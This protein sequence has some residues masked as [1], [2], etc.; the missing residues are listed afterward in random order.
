MQTETKE[1]ILLTKDMTAIQIALL[2]KKEK[3]HI[4]YAVHKDGES[5]GG[6]DEQLGHWCIIYRKCRIGPW[7]DDSE[8]EWVTAKYEM[9]VDGKPTHNESDW[10]EV[11]L[12]P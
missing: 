3:P 10:T 1:P 8:K 2:C 11:K 6:F 4:R 7:D 12:N 5:V 9:L